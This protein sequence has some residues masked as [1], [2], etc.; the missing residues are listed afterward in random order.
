M[1]PCTCRVLDAGQAEP[2][3]KPHVLQDALAGV[4]K[5]QNIPQLLDAPIAKHFSHCQEVR[6]Q[7]LHSPDRLP[8]WYL[9]YLQWALPHTII[10][11]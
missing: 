4:A 3:L 6:Y 8:L 1:G 10:G 7:T 5:E 9:S 2:V 11:S